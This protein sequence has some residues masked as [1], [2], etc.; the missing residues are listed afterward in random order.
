MAE[1]SFEKDE[2]LDSFQKPPFAIADVTN[3]EIFSG[4]KLSELIFEDIRNE[5]EQSGFVRAT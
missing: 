1:V 3:N 4:G 2:E 5:V